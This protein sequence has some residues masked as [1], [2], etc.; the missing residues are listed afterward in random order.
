LADEDGETEVGGELEA[1]L[2]C[3][4]AIHFPLHSS[5]GGQLKTYITTRATAVVA[6]V[7]RRDDCG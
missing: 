3:I 2:A 1:A 6:H 4:A 7:A 5:M